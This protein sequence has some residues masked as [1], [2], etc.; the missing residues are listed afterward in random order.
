MRIATPMRMAV[1]IA[2][3]ACVA[4][5]AIVDRT[6]SGPELPPPSV[7]ALPALDLADAEAER[8]VDLLCGTRPASLGA[9][10]AGLEVGQVSDRLSDVILPSPSGVT[11]SLLTTGRR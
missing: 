7:E 5:V 1:R 11:T 2:L 6:R 9:G 8:T 4:I 10:F 3:A